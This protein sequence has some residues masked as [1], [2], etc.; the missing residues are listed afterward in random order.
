MRKIINEDLEKYKGYLTEEKKCLLCGNESK[1][2]WAKYGSFKAVKCPDCGLIWINPSINNQ[3]LDRYYQNYIDMRFKD[4]KKTSQRAIQYKIDKQFIENFISSGKV[5][6]IGCSGGFFLNE[7]SNKFKKFG[8]ELDEAAVDYA[9]R[10]YS[11]G[12]N[13]MKCSLEE[14]KFPR[15]SFDLIVMRGVIEHLPLPDVNI[16][17]VSY[18]LKKGGFFYI[19]ATPNADSFCADIYREKWNQF[20][21]IRHLYY[22]SVKTIT[23]F[24]NKYGLELIAKDFPYLETPYADIKKDHIAMIKA[25]LA[26]NDGGFESIGRS[27]PFW[28]NMMNLVFKKT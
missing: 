28:G 21:P 17:K 8:V 12:K 1:S 11:F 7:L 18:L 23:R 2:I 16:K 26:K 14:F 5:L 20:H 27:G 24:L 9:K 6:D 13:I 3:G 10:K 15:N 25:Y 19:A 4:K 22:F